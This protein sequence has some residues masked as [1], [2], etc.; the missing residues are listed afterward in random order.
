M[1]SLVASIL[2]LKIALGGCELQVATMLY[3]QG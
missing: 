3:F 2:L 1:D